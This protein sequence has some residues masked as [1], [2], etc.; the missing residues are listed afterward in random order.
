MAGRGFESCWRQPDR[1]VVGGG[2][3]WMVSHRCSSSGS[4]VVMWTVPVG[5]RA[6]V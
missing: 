2:G 5:D 4:V 6:V 3:G 1:F